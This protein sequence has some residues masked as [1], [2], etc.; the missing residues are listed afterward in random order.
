[1]AVFINFY[2]KLQFNVIK[3]DN[4]L[5]DAVLTAKF[6]TF[7]LLTFEFLLDR[8]FSFCHI[9]PKLLAFQFLR[10]SVIELG[11]C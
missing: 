8:K 1:M 6:T 4:K 2:S 11:H 7:N 10:G 3:I 5:L 9:L